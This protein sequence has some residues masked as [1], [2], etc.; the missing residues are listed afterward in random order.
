MA[1]TAAY[2][3]QTD[4]YGQRQSWL[5]GGPVSLAAACCRVIRERPPDSHTGLSMLV[6]G[7]TCSLL[8][9]VVPQQRM[10][11]VGL[12]NRQQFPGLKHVFVAQLSDK[13][14]YHVTRQPQ[15]H[16]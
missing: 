8:F 4:R 13:H 12:G 5:C 9:E 14:I 16:H 2:L 11:T 3:E 7:T 1:A 6:T 15:N 10:E